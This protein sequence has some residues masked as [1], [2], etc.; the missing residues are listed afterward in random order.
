MDQPILKP[1]L[2]FGNNDSF[3]MITVKL[4]NKNIKINKNII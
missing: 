4:N 1:L 3:H 2:V